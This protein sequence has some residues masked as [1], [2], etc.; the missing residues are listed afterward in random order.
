[1][2]VCTRICILLYKL[3]LHPWF[4]SLHSIPI[5]RFFSFLTSLFQFPNITR[6]MVV[7]MCTCSKSFLHSSICSKLV[8]GVSYSSI[9][10]PHVFTLHFY[11]LLFPHL[12]RSVHSISTKIYISCSLYFATGPNNVDPSSCM[13]S[14]FY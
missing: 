6:T 1:M 10:F 3:T 14:A 8:V 9:M 7:Q 11:S 5:S 4:I 13:C 2:C 12:P